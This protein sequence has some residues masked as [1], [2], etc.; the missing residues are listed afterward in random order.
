MSAG[1]NLFPLIAIFVIE[2]A[3]FSYLLVPFVADSKNGVQ[4][5]LDW[6]LPSFDALS[7]CLFPSSEPTPSEPISSLA[8]YKSSRFKHSSENSVSS[9]N[10]SEEETLSD[11]T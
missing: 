1:C 6:A 5:D 7:R 10:E 2:L 9:T 4:D 8:S 11:V 3:T